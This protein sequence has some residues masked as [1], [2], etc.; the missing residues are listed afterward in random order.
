MKSVFFNALF[1]LLTLPSALHAGSALNKYDRALGQV[2]AAHRAAQ[3]CN[4]I[5]HLGGRDFQQYV[6]RVS[7]ILKSQGL[8]KNKVRRLMFYGDSSYLSQLG[9]VILNDRG[10][11]PYQTDQLCSLARKIAGTKDPIG[12][13]LKSPE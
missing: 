7:D 10:V 9:I 12:R 2:M 11:A 1:V 13:F 3:K 5:E 4:G 8:R 6:L